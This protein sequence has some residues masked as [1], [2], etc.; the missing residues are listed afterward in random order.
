MGKPAERASAS[1]ERQAFVAALARLG[2]GSYQQYLASPLWQS[3]RQRVFEK[4]GR[5]CLSCGTNRATEV[6]HRQY[7][8]A[9]LRGETLKHLDPICGHCHEIS[10]GD[11]LWLP[12]RRGQ[13]LTRDRRE[14]S[15]SR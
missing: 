2:F 5:T 15:R 9:T 10:H 8:V 4:K 6:H 1:D 7:D 3:I 14:R 12:S 11:K 13:R